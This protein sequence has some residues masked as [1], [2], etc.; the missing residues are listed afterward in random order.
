MTAKARL[1]AITAAIVRAE[2]ASQ[3][4]AN[5]ETANPVISLKVVIGVVG[6][7]LALK[8]NADQGAYVSPI[9]IYA[10]P[11]TVRTIQVA[12]D[13]RAVSATHVQTHA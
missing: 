4:T 11:G 2:H 6:R 5:A 7:I 9:P 8:A 10:L 3:M 1:T 13:A 12:P